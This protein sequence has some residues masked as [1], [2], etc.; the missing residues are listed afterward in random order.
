[1]KRRKPLNVPVHAHSESETI[2]SSLEDRIAF[3]ELNRGIVRI[4]DPLD[5]FSTAEIMQKIEYLRAKGVKHINFMIT[6]P[7]GGVYHSL[8]LYDRISF[9]PKQGVKTTAIVEG[10]AASA[11][12]ML[13]LQ[14]VQKRTATPNSRFLLHEP[15]RW[16]MFAM[17]R[18]SDIK[19]ESQEMNSITDVIYSIV[20]KRCKRAKSEVA[21]VIDRK[22][23]WMSA[24]Q[25][26][27]FRLI[28]SIIK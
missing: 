5:E 12:A 24:Q 16:T 23:V 14:A 17:E 28:D 10:Y 1:M 22:E 7:G 9:L 18:T 8:A 15:R 4:S 19:D 27:K 20:A 26:L 11:A 2:P 13:V 21:K 25:A 6:S 3:S